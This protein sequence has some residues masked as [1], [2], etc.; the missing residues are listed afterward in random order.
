MH[1]KRD[2]RP[3]QSVAPAVRDGRYQ[4]VSY[5]HETVDIVPGEPLREALSCDVAIVG[6][7]F[8]GL[9]IAYHLKRFHPS[10]DV[11]LLEQGVV[12][13]GASG[14]NGG[15]AMPLLGWD[16]LDAVKK[17]GEAEAG[18]AYR[19]MYAA[20]DHVKAVVREHAI[21]CDL[22]ATGYLLLHTCAARE[23]RARKEL[24]SAQD[25]KSVV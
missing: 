12:G 4:P 17:L 5:W 21:D 10:L 13:H 18:K 16:L 3:F 1:L 14:R 2:D 6:G 15:F 19:L 23:K 24:E 11:V 22:E 20:V 7:G 9:S 8:T 25:R